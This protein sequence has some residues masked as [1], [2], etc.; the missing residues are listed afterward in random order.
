AG[1]SAAQCLGWPLPDGDSPVELYVPD[2]SLV[3]MIE[4]H[5]LEPATDRVAE[6]VLRAVPDA[7]TFPPHQRV[8]PEVIAALDLAE[9]VSPSV[10]KLGRTRLIELGDGIEPSWERRPQRRRPP[11]SIVPSGPRA[12][13]PYPRLQHSAVADA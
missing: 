4:A 12:P 8:V 11:R 7:W 3:D 6:I 13:R 2:A 1:T 5:A 10:A 9:S